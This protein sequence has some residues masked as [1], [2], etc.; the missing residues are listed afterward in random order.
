MREKDLPLMLEGIV[1]SVVVRHLLPVCIEIQ[2]IGNVWIPDC[3]RGVHAALN[4]ASTQSCNGTAVCAIDLQG[5]QFI[6]IHAHAPG[7][8]KVCDNS[9]LQFESGIRSIVGGAGIGDPTLIHPLRDM[10]RAQTGNRAH[11]AKKIGE[12][13]FPVAE[14]VKNDAASLLLAIIPGGTLGGLPVSLENP[15][16]ELAAYCKDTAQEAALN[17]AL[18]L[19]QT[20]QE[21]LILYN[22]MLDSCPLRH[23]RQFK[24]CC[25]IGSDGFLAVEMLAGPDRRFQA[26]GTQGGRLRIKVDR[27]VRVGQAGL[28]I[29][30]PA[31]DIVRPCERAQLVLVAANQERVGY[32]PIA[33]RQCNPALLADRHN[34]A[35]EMLVGSHAPGDAVHDNS[36]RADRHNI[37]SSLFFLIVSYQCAAPD[38]KK[39]QR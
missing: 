31:L 21:K 30:T 9:S 7:R 1:K 20:G 23:A 32:E 15:V 8:V 33:V 16:A 2:R 38:Y 14:H 10:R 19:E 37:L 25:Q 11:R 35:D 28:K 13:I 36:N 34:R 17:N 18:Q 27:V 22:A 3:A 4:L 12:H 24:S 5:E 29:C 39:E 6:T 26:R